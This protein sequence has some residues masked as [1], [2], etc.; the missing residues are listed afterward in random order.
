[1]AEKMSLSFAFLP[2]GKGSTPTPVY[3]PEGTIV[4]VA[5]NCELMHKLE[6]LE[7]TSVYSPWGEIVVG[8]I[9]ERC[10]AV[11]A[12]PVSVADLQKIAQIMESYN[13]QL[14]IMDSAGD[15]KFPSD[16]SLS[17]S[18]VFAAGV[19]CMDRAEL[20]ILLVFQCQKLS[21]SCDQ[22]SPSDS[23]QLGLWIDEEFHPY[24]SLKE[25]TPARWSEAEAVFFPGAF[26]DFQAEQLAR[27]NK[28]LVVIL[29]EPWHLLLSV[30]KWE[31]MS[32]EGWR[33]KVRKRARFLMAS[34]NPVS[35]N[36]DRVEAEFYLDIMKANLPDVPVLNVLNE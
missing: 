23:A 8:R 27:F 6:I 1:M 4:G 24:H 15:R 18:F 26:S 10:R 5:R 34:F 11:L 14:L 12:G 13:P 22:R 19:E 2:V 20:G 25:I 31:A 33:F 3:L 32:R 28:P 7:G 21:L 30:A 9:H 36:G 29:K 17:D 16:S 35:W